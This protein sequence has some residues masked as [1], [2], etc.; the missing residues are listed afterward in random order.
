M[1]KI[2]EEQNK[3]KKMPKHFHLR[4]VQIYRQQKTVINPIFPSTSPF[5]IPNSNN[6][7][8]SIKKERSDDFKDPYIGLFL[9]D[10]YEVKKKLGKGA[11]GLV[12]LVDDT[13]IEIK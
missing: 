6:N 13:K 1:K 12:Y 4:V 2:K 7:N 10:R 11:F 8:N 5:Y 9:S 3:N